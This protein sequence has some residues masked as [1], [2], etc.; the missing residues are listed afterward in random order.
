MSEFANFPLYLFFA[1]LP[2][3]LWLNFYL[4]EDQRP[5]PKLMVL[6]VFLLGMIIA[7][8]TVFFEIMVVGGIRTLNFSPKIIKISQIFLGVA[9]IEEF[10][11]F[12]VVKLAVFKSKELDEPVDFMIYMIISGLGFAATESIFLFLPLR[13][14]I[15]GNIVRV[16]LTRFVGP[17]FLHALSSAIFGFFLGLSF[18]KPKER[19][20]LFLIGLFF[21]TLLHGFY[22]FF[23]IEM[24]E[25]AGFFLPISLLLI[26]AFVV[27]FCFKTLK[28]KK[29]LTFLKN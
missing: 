20:K 3:F 16:S 15:L 1:I 18:F 2:S 29:W 21:A 22:N 28:N 10:F 8:I 26:T 25:K 13:N 23:I 19:L 6:S 27:S 24:D 11:K 12:L 5:E 14:E 9:L 17:T 7:V 4:K